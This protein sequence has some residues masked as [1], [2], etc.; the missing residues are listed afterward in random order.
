[1][2]LLQICQLHVYDAPLLICHMPN[3]LR[4]IEIWGLCGTL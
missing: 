3:M 2:Q 4:E 1:M